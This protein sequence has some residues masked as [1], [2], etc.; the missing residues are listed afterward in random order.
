MKTGNDWVKVE[1]LSPESDMIHRPQTDELLF[2]RQVASGDVEAITENCRQ[3]RFLDKEGVGTLSKDPVLNLKYHFVVTAALVSRICTE[4]G[5]EMEQSFRL[6]DYYIGKLDFASNE[7]EIE[8]WHNKMVL[9]YTRRMQ[10]LKQSSSLSRPVSECMNYIYAHIKDR[11]TIDDLAAVT[12]N[13][14]SYISR[15]FKSEVG[16][17]VS[18]YIRKV[19][20]D[21]A[22]N[23]LRFSDFTLVEIAQYLSFSSQSHF[24]KLFKEETKMTPKKYRSMYYGTHWKGSDDDFTGDQLM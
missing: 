5:M 8:K 6:S 2:Y 9:D 15:L 7:E 12:G 14:P 3:H 24:I 1:F 11:V 10:L 20:L 16:V 17:P 4:N 19:K 21:K 23:L 18:D 13:S 22:K